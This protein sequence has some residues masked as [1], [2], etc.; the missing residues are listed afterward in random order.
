[1]PAV[2]PARRRFAGRP[3]LGLGDGP[4]E[5]EELV[6][7]VRPRH[8]EGDG[9][10]QVARL[11]AAIEAAALEAEGAD[12]VA[13]RD[14]GG[15]GVGQLDLAAG[16]GLDLL[17][18]AQ[19]LRRQDVAADHRH[20]RRRDLGL[21]LLHHAAHRHRRRRSRRRRRGCHRT[22]RCRPAPPSSRPCCRRPRHR[23]RSSACRQGSRRRSR[24][25]AGSPRRA[26]RRSVPGAPDRVAE[27]AAFLLA[28][29]G[30]A[31]LSMSVCFSRSSR[32]CLLPSCRLLELGGAVEV[33]LERALA[34]RGHEDELA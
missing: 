22:R 8:A 32:C 10:L 7:Q 2:R 21:R 12:V 26:R 24:R 29:I 33:V 9:G 13:R 6:A 4:Q 34:A 23:P 14:L 18:V 30:D 15:D 16:A 31:P 27:A 20:V 1:M 17:E 28:D 5:I 25:R 19:D 11:R 3:R